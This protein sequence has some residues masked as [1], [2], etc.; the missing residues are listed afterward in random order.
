[1]DKL[2]HTNKKIVLISTYC[3]TDE[4]LEILDTNIEKIKS[5]GLDV[6]VNSPI[7]LPLNIINKCDYFY[8]TKD[9]PILEWPERAVY[10]WKKISI[11][12]EEIT[13][14]RCFDDYGWAHMY[15]IKKLIE[16][17]LT[18]D[19]ELFYHIIYDTIIDDVV[20]ASFMSSTKKCNFYPFHEHDVSFHLMVFNRENLITFLSHLTL[21][22][23]LDNG[24]IVENWLTNLLKTNKF[25]HTIE[26]HKVN[27]KILFHG[28]I[29]LH[30]YS[31]NENLIY[32]IEKDDT[33]LDNIKIYFY[34]NNKTSNIKIVVM[35]KEYNYVINDGDFI[36][37]GYNQNDIKDTIIEY[38]NNS[39]NITDDILRIKH[40]TISKIINN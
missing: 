34:N 11:K 21:N 32:F 31:K 19:Y 2:K 35:N 29:D 37:L 12:D 14:T 8:L 16:F 20:E 26:K 13:M 25:K 33:N 28:H 30:N 10:V 9:N 27:D 6:M 22:S 18:Y 39:Y 23:Y 4:K 36:D 17:A 5:L 3:D 7:S 40:N 15:Q 1:M 38:D 24:G